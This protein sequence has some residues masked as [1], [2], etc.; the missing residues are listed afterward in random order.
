MYNT[1]TLVAD[2]F[3]NV[4]LDYIQLENCVRYIGPS[5]NETMHCHDV[6]ELCYCIRG[7]HIINIGKNANALTF[8]SHDMVGYPPHCEHQGKLFGSQETIVLWLYIPQQP[9]LPKCSFKIDDSNGVLRWLCENIFFEFSNRRNK[10]ADL[11]THYTKSLILNMIRILESNTR[12]ALQD[13]ILFLLE[14]ID[15]N[16]STDI[17]LD[18]TSNILNI[19]KSHLH[20][21]FKAHTGITPLQYLQ[22]ARISTAKELLK[23][24]EL[25]IQDVAFEVGYQDQRYFSRIFKNKTGLSPSAWRKQP[26]I[27]IE[28]CL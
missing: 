25:S 3:S 9:N 28:S 19:S 17:S 15:K 11:L 18:Q 6:L 5:K 27:I 16:C 2:Y 1:N 7:E 8:H 12:C 20:K 22:E 21:V 13:S 23:K 10:S 26:S 4:D 24:T 14:Y